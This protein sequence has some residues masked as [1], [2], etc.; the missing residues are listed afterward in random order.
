[1][2]LRPWFI[3][4]GGLLFLGGLFFLGCSVVLFFIGNNGVQQYQT[5]LGQI[6]YHLSQSAQNQLNTYMLM[7]A[8]GIFI[9]IMSFIVMAAGVFLGFLGLITTKPVQNQ[10]TAQSQTPKSS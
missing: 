8:A 4:F 7:E 9:G 3:I 5:F 1:M 6:E 10:P 2:V